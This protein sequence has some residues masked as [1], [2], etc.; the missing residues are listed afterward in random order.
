MVSTLRY[1]FLLGTLLLMEACTKN[2]FTLEFSLASDVT[3]NYNV[4]YY[5][6]DLNGGKT[7]QAVASVRE[8][9]CELKGITK[10]PTLV[11]VTTRKSV[12]P[13]VMY[14]ERGQKFDITGDNREPL[15][16]KV[17]G[18]SINEQ[19]S[20]WRLQNKDLF[21]KNNADS[22]NLAVKNFVE[23][24][25]SNP[26]STILM[27]CYFNREEDERDYNEIMASLSED[28]RNPDLL[29]M[30]G[31][32]DQLYHSYS[33]PARLDNMIMK[34]V[35]K[36]GD[37]LRIDNKNPV[38][39]VFWQTGYDKRNELIDSLKVMEKEFPD[40]ARIIADICVDVDSTSW[41][42]T[43]RKDSLY[44]EM[45]RFWA[46]MGMNDATVMKFKVA[47]LPYYIVFDKY[48]NQSY[49]GNEI[50]EAMEDYRNHFHSKDSI[51]T[52]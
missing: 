19:L 40:S 29:R 24:N 21:V 25:T 44:K 27:L 41:R 23:E 14:V 48:G 39:L 52:K 1:I 34:S 30:I 12:F 15:D 11:Y 3:D 26:V 38:F 36:K 43:M 49:R 4:T 28:A 50:S 46:P 20:E 32:A 35:N 37:T 17:D 18:N 45:K 9:K 33:F 10:L 5:A 31:R 42:S 2:E 51:L 47:K 13:L 8:G 16:W 22:I 7:I 6:T